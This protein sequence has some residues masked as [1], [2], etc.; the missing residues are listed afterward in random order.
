MQRHL[1]VSLLTIILLLT[2]SAFSGAIGLRVE[3]QG[4]DKYTA[5]GVDFELGLPAIPVRGVA[6]LL[7][8]VAMN[9]DQTTHAQ[10][11]LGVRMY[12]A[13]DSTGP[14]VEAKMRYILPLDEKDAE[15]STLFMYGAGYRFKPLIG[16]VDVFVTMTGADHDIIAK[17]LLVGARIGF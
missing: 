11:G 9:D 15:G 13:S 10:A 7:G 6:E 4:L 5:A 16:G 17:Q 12:L 3:T 14:F 1:R 2:V 8:W